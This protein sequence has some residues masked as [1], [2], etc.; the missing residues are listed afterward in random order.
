MSAVLNFL[1]ALRIFTPLSEAMTE[2]QKQELL[3]E[4]LSQ[5]TMYSMVVILVPSM[6]FL[7]TLL[8]YTFKKITAIT[9]LT[10]DDLLLK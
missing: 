9:G 4:Q 6:I 5:M 10:S 3:N 1:L 7:G 2:L 8:F